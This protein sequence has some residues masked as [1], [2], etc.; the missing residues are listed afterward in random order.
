[1][2]TRN[3]VRANEKPATNAAGHT[4][5]IPRKP[6]IAQI[7][8]KGTI[9][10]KRGNCRPTIADNLS[11][12]M[13]VTAERAIMGVP[14][15]PNATGAVFAIKARPHAANGL[16]PSC[17]RMAAVMATGVP[18]PAAPSKKAPKANAINITC[19]LGSGAIVERCI[20]MMVN[21]PLFTVNWYRKIKFNTIQPMGNKP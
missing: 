11:T 12:S 16:K 19:T 2:E 18:N 5:I 14:K 6:T 9:N 21:K 7:T 10:E 15:A 13:P 20:L 4:L 1:M 17:I 3:W 8:Q